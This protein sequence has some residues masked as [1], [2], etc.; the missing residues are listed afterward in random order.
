MVQILKLLPSKPEKKH[1]V[2]S[3]GFFFLFRERSGE[4][5]RYGGLESGF[6]SEVKPLQRQRM[7]IVYYW[8]AAKGYD[9][10]ADAKRFGHQSG[11]KQLISIARAVNAPIRF[12]SF[13]WSDKQHWYRNRSPTFRKRFRPFNGRRRTSHHC[14]QAEH[15]SKERTDCGAKD[16]EMIEKKTAMTSWFG[17]KGFYSDLYES[18]FWEIDLCPAQ[19]SFCYSL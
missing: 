9:T 13:G 6:W 3:S 18:Q 4:N 8:K 14:P 10:D 7:P 5:I 15:H 19:R 1:G 2:C 12:F 11:Q 17:L 16:G